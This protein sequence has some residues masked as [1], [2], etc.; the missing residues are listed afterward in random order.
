MDLTLPSMLAQVC[1]VLDGL[2]DYVLE[3]RNFSYKKPLYLPDGYL[4][5]E[6]A[7]GVD[8][9]PDMGAGAFDGA[10]D[11][12]VRPQGGHAAGRNR[13][14]WFCS[15]GQRVLA[16]WERGVSVGEDPDRGAGLSACLNT[17]IWP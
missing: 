8:E 7:D 15:P 3:R 10:D 11:F 17:C 4:E 1:G 5:D 9:D 12:K 13:T 16:G 14:E 2:V 6:A